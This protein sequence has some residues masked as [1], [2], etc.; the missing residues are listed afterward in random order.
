MNISKSSFI[1]GLDCPLKL[2]NLLW[3]PDAAGKRAGIDELKMQFGIRF[4][5][6]AHCLYPDAKLIDIDRFH[7]DRAE[8]DT[9]M[10]IEGGA[11]QILEATFRHE[12]CRVI[13]DIVLKQDDGT[14]HLIEVKSAK[15]ID[16]K[17]YH[18][19]AYQ[20]FVMERRGYPVSR[21]SVI[22]ANGNG[23]WPDARSI[24]QSEDVTDRVD[25]ALQ[26]V[27]D[28]LAPMLEIAN[29]KDARPEFM[30]SVSK[31]CKDCEFKKT[32]C[33]KDISEPTIYDVIR[34]E[35]IPLLRADDIFYIK[36]VPHNF[37]LS[38]TNRR[39]VDCMQSKGTSIDRPAIRSMLDDL[40]Y[41]LYFLDFESISVA[42]PLFDGNHPW[43]KL[44][45]QY[46]VHKL[47]EDGKLTHL[48]YLHE[49][50]SDP[51]LPLADHLVK[52]IG[53][54]GSVIVYFKTMESGV[55]TDLASRFPQHA[56]ALLSIDARIWDLHVVFKNHYRHWQFGSRASIK[57]VLPVLVPD[58]DHADEQI[59]DG[60]EASLNWIAML[61]TD[62]E[63]VRQKKKQDLLSY[64]R[65]D[66][67]AMVRLLDVV[68][69]E[70]AGSIP[71]DSG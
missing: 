38:A 24:F 17:Y 49:E 41:P 37:K 16:P 28:Q 54:K 15:E 60:G 39:D 13:S 21:C 50:Y 71:A 36:D 32:V 64:C 47:D 18:D 63:T 3:N 46:S 27:P 70:V 45:F 55:L 35:K 19:I 30:K 25:L 33:W 7:L 61:E 5:E 4:G 67:L 66:T 11:T 9:Q 1:A 22:F 57:I 40:R 44:P 68:Q 59:S 8:R 58:L 10:A 31:K 34:A 48:E 62:D 42:T 51:S 52:D 26:E 56:K 20:K 69:T 53:E 2:W 43:Q 29:S 6:L 12:Q 23:T 65:L 14:W